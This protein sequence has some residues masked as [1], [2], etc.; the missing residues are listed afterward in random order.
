M[1]TIKITNVLQCDYD[2]V[3][4]QLQWLIA[5]DSR[6]PRFLGHS[7]PRPGARFDSRQVK[8]ILR[9]DFTPASW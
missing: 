2:I 4:S 6:I 8:Q 9:I 3:I 7:G 1:S 5:G